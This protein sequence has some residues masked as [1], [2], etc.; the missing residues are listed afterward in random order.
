[1][2]CVFSTQF[3]ISVLDSA[4]CAAWGPMCFLSIP[5]LTPKAI[6]TW[7][8]LPHPQQ[9]THWKHGFGITFRHPT[10]QFLRHFK[11]MFEHEKDTDSVPP[12]V[13]SLESKWDAAVVTLA[14]SDH[15][16]MQPLITW[17]T[18]WK[19][20]IG[21]KVTALIGYMAENQ[22]KSSSGAMLQMGKARWVIP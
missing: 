21:D 19:D 15:V 12:L 6:S 10:G 13:T 16:L 17:T 1:M 7:W 9:K 8:A 14:A 2:R 20:A 4:T 22:K 11:A 3:P 18:K 5:S